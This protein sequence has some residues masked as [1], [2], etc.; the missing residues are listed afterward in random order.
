MPKNEGEG[1]K[2]PQTDKQE[3]KGSPRNNTGKGKVEEDTWTR[4]VAKIAGKVTWVNDQT[5]KSW[6]TNREH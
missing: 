5:G 4:Y 6:A 3:E 2:E 1:Y